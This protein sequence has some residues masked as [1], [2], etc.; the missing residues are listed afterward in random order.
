MAVRNIFKDDAACLYKTA[1]PVEKFDEKL[2]KLL[3]DMAETM[4]A[5]E[6]VGLAA[7]QVGI[8]RRVFVMDCG[9]G[10]IEAIN[11]E[12]L[13]TSGEQGGMEGCLSFP[14]RSGYVVRPN[15]VKFRAFDRRGKLMQ[16]TC[17]GL[18]ARCV[19]HENDHL[20]GHVYL[21]KVTEPPEGFDPNA[22]YDDEE[23]D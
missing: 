14:E 3:D 20:D 11:P 23:D 13:E 5:A 7:P 1:R 15:K 9:D 19:L 22:G 21:E 12:I 2:W 4:Y 8:L 6:G 17:E 18:H 16:Y 10:L